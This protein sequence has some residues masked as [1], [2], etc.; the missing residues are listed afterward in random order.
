[1]IAFSVCFGLV[2]AALDSNIIGLLFS[3][4]AIVYAAIVW[5][6]LSIGMI[7]YSRTRQFSAYTDFA[8]NIALAREHLS[9]L[10]VLAVFVFVVGL[11][12]GIV[13]SI[14]CVGW[15]VGLVSVG[16]NAIVTGH[17]TGQAAVL[18]TQAGGGEA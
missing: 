13:T 8:R 9:T 4:I 15:L 5:M 1:L 3:L 16:I 17:L 10:V 12:L 14:P 7:R 18:I 11:V 6:P 2:M